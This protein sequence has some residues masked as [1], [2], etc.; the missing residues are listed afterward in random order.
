MLG[1]LELEPVGVGEQR[2]GLHAEQRVVGHGVFS[3]CVMAV[4]G[5]EQ[6][7]VQPAGDLYELGIRTMLVGDP[8]ILDL[9]EEVLPP[10]D[11]LQA[12][13]PALGLFDIAGQQRLEDDAAQAPGGGDQPGVMA[14]EQLPIDPGL[15]VVALQVRRRRELQEVAV[16]LDGLGKQGEVVVQL[17][18]TFGISPGVVHLAPAHRSLMSG[19]AGHVG[20]GPDDGGDPLVTARLVEVQDSVHVAVIGDA[21]SRLP[22]GHCRGHQL[23]DPGGPIEHGELGVGVQMRKRPLRHPASFQ[24]WNLQLCHSIADPDLTPPQTTLRTRIT[25]LLTILSCRV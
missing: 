2:S 21:Q 10:E 17:L 20:L 24:Q 14:L 4:V 23:A 9:D 7:R 3:M 18:P 16:A 5:G 11:V 25:T 6:R 13:R 1:P 12:R 22:V 15:V 8:V 19:F